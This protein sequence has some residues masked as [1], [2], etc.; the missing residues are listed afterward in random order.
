VLAGSR[1]AA[2]E[3]RA[4]LLAEHGAISE[5]IQWFGGPGQNPAP[6]EIPIELFQDRV[7]GLARLC[8]RVLIIGLSFGAEAALVTAS[9]TPLVDAVVAFSPSDV[10]WAGV[11]PEGKQTSHWS[12][13]GSPLPFVPFAEDWEPEGD[14]PSYRDLYT[15]S[16]RLRPDAVAAAAIEVERIPTLIQVV[17]GDDLVWP[18]D[19]HAEA[20]T[21]RRSTH[22]LPTVNLTDGEAGHRAILPGESPVTTGVSMQ[23]GGTEVANRRL[24]D[25]AWEA[26][27]SVL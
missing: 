24:G 17:G 16:R 25:A 27:S 21:I 4:R 23:R 26:I 8:D 19:L 11:A 6:F 22:G 5:S 18:A 7:E 14:P 3:T 9:R 10:V 1:G 20:V 15:Y 13:D 2:D 12:V